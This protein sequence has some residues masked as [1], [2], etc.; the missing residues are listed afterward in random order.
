MIGMTMKQAAGGFFDRAKVKRAVDAATRR[1]LSK[2]GAFVRRR[3]R[4]SIRARKAV[5]EPGQPPTNRTGV[6]RDGI[7]FAYEQ[8]FRPNVVIGPVLTNQSARAHRAAQG[9]VPQVLEEG[10]EIIVKTKKQSR[11]AR[12]QARPY[13]QPAFEKE[14]QLTLPQLW[15][16]SVK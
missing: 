9:T 1:V 8:S 6:L 13:M 5:S 3:A 7:I 16:G 10:G 14:K 12:I 2:F 4:S 11:L 15:K